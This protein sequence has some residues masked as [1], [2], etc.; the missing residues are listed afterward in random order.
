MVVAAAVSFIAL[1]LAKVSLDLVSK[2]LQGQ[3]DQLPH[4]ILRLAARRLPPA[5]RTQ[6]FED[7]EAELDYILR[8]H[9]ARPITRLLLGFRFATSLLRGARRL[10]ADHMNQPKPSIGRAVHDPQVASVATGV[11]RSRRSLV[12]RTAWI[13]LGGRCGQVTRSGARCRCLVL[14]PHTRCHMH[15]RGATHRFAAASLAR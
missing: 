12:V 13:F 4:R 7:W 11:R 10:R 14:F 9:D 6:Y 1:L 5:L 3:M 2:E 15:R 8:R